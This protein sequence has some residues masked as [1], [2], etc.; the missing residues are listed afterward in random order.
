MTAHCVFNQSPHGASEGG[1]VGAQGG[2]MDVTVS[3][4]SIFFF[5]TIN[6]F[7]KNFV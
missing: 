7:E 4:L 2:Q 3:K 5:K 6:L 1:G